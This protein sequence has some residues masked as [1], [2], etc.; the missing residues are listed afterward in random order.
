MEAT[1]SS[2]LAG[3]A[4]SWRVLITGFVV[5]LGTGYLVAALNA[6]MSVGITPADIAG[7]Y[8]DQTLSA[9]E[10]EVMAE[11]GFVE[12]E[13]SF[14][15]PAETDSHAGHDMAGMDAGN[16]AHGDMSGGGE[17]ITPEQMAELAHIHLLGFS[18]ILASAGVLACLTGLSEVKKTVLVGGLFLCLSGDIGGLY[19]VR[20]VSEKFAVLNWLAGAGI[21][22]CLLLIFLRVLWEVWG[23]ARDGAA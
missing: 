21:G 7:H 5:I 16:M 2:R 6:A 20:F 1:S 11:Q 18:M 19:L 10:Q 13:F 9:A 17:S 15:E 3:L 14:D 22:A 8:A 4:L 12:E 23:G